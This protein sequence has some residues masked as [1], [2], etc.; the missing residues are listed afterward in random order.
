MSHEFADERRVNYGDAVFLRR[1][2][3]CFRFVK[4]DDEALCSPGKPNATCKIHGRVEMW[5]EGYY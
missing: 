1:C 5:F 4:A 2:P 3:I